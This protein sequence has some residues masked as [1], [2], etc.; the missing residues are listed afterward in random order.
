MPEQICAVTMPKWGIEMTEGTINHWA[1][2]EGEQVQKGATLLE[3]ETEKIVNTV[4]AP[5]SGTLRRII[6]NAGEVR[7]VGSLIAVLADATVS[8][9]EVAS[10]I[11]RFEGASVSF[12]PEAP[13]ASMREASPAAP[14][15]PTVPAAESVQ[16]EVR[17]SPVARRLAEQLGIDIKQV[18]PAGGNA[19]ITKEDVEA[20]AARPRTG[21]TAEPGAGDNPVTRV[22]L[23][24]TR[25]TIGRRLTA[26]TQAIPHY[27]VTVEID[28]GPLQAQRRA[29]GAQSVKSSLNDMVLRACALALVRHP[30]L[31][32]QLEGEEVLQYAHADIAIAVATD[33][34][35]LT[36][37]VRAADQKSLA[38]LAR[39][40]AAL[41]Q[42]ARSGALT[43]EEISGGTFSISNLGMYGVTQFDAIINPPQV[44]I[45]A[46]GAVRPAV[47]V[48]DGAAVVG[49]LL[50]LTLSADHRAIDGAQAAEFMRTVTE[51]T[52][53]P[54]KL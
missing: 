21:A 11:A 31:N 6:A 19:R 33:T 45:L 20:Y 16:T 44:A 29:L 13:V 51:L 26:A 7:P 49:E 46:V 2:Q 28:A 39:E 47:V 53:T 12:E 22:P 9:A 41:A 35:L 24:A 34:G 3:V 42:K 23:S 18:R 54:G 48:R 40:T 37:I 1:T 52:G 27:R 43:R 8:E 15:P 5:A 32:A 4:E 14:A 17:V 30:A 36:P 10:F 50:S 25:L 38:E